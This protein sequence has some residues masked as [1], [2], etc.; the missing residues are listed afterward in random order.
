MRVQ[1]ITQKVKEHF[2]D[3]VFLIPYNE[4]TKLSYQTI[5]NHF[6]KSTRSEYNSDETPIIIKIELEKLDQCEIIRN[7]TIHSDKKNIKLQEL[8][9]NISDLKRHWENRINYED[10]KQ[11][12]EVSNL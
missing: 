8:R 12:E 4:K 5:F 7:F 10:Y 11:M 9:S 6:R 1:Q 2:I 3:S